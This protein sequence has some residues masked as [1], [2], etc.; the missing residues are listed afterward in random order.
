MGQLMLMLLDIHTHM[1]LM[2]HQSPLLPVMLH[3]TTTHT[4]LDIIMPSASVKPNLILRLNLMP[5]TTT[6]AMPMVILMPMDTMA[7]LFLMLVLMPVMVTAFA[8][9]PVGGKDLSERIPA[10]NYLKNKNQIKRF[11]L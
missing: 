8:A 2:P 3:H 4:V 9:M 6:M 5:G 1:L 10:N 11:L 7:T